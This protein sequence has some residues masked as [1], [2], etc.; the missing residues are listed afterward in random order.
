M[1]WRTFAQA[2]VSIRA[3]AWGATDLTQGDAEAV[4]VSIR[5]PAWGATRVQRGYRSRQK[6]F[7][8][9]SR[10]GSDDEVPPGQ[11]LARCFNSRS[12]M[13]SD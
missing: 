6:R 13:G 10:M 3:P 9:R 7:N 4:I 8:S 11:S 1:A 5:A 2:A 12:R